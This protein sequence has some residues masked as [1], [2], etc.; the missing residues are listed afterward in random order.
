MTPENRRRNLQQ[1]WTLSDE[2]W[3]DAEDLLMLGRARGAVGRY[4]YAS[5][6][7]AQGALLTR[8]LEP[9]THA[10]V[11][12]EFSRVFVQTGILTREEAQALTD[13]QKE[14]E[15]ADYSRTATFEQQDAVDARALTQRFRDAVAAV[16]RTE[17][18]ME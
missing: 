16:L 2:A 4:Y 7:A 6:H 14:R 17:G 1:E 18:W 8:E 12:S 3:Q 5:F 11:R 9:K 15:A 10:G 13:L